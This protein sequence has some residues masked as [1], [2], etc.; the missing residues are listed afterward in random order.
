M[1]DPAVGDDGQPL[2][3]ARYKAFGQ[4]QAQLT[5]EFRLCSV[6]VGGE[7]LTGFRQ[8]NPIVDAANPYGTRFDASMV[9]GPTDGAM[10]YAGI[11]LNLERF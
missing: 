10:F 9:W 4:L 3:N 11:R 1:P 7:N 2:W 8:K 5:R 6:Y